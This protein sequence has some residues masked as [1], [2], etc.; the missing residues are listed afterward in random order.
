VIKR[1]NNADAYAIAVGHLADR[2][3]G[4][5]S[6][7]GEWPRKDDALSRREK[8]QLQKRLTRAGFSTDGVD[9]II[10]PN[11]ISAVRRYQSSIG[12]IPDG[13]ISKKLL[14]RLR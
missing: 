4:G 7:V 13:Y 14:A 5:G 12:L 6:F 9:G 8:I 10:G 11:T 3:M 1:Y 2:I